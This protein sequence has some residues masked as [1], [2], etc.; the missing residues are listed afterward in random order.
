MSKTLQERL[1]SLKDEVT[2]LLAAVIVDD[3]STA[4]DQANLLVEKALEQVKRIRNVVWGP[5]TSTPSNNTF[6]C[7][8]KEEG[9]HE[10]YKQCIVSSESSE[11]K[12][13]KTER[14]ED[15]S[16]ESLLCNQI[17]TEK[18]EDG[19]DSDKTEDLNYDNA[20]DIDDLDDINF[21]DDNFSNIP[22]TPKI[23]QTKAQIKVDGEPSFDEDD[24]RNLIKNYNNNE[25]D[26]VA[27]DEEEFSDEFDDDFNEDDMQLLEEAERSIIE[28]E[29]IGDKE[30]DDDAANQPEDKKFLDVLKQYFGYS[31][32]RPM[33]WKIINSVV[34]EKKDNCVI[35]A[36][37]HGKSLC[38][39]YPS[40]FTGKTTVVISPL[41][42]LMEDQ[43]LGLKAANIEACLLGS[44]QENS[45]QVMSELMRGQY[46]VLYITP[47]YASTGSNVLTDLNTKIGIDL[48]AIDEAHC[49]SQW[50]HDFRSAYRSLGSLKD[51]FPDVPVM[52]L[53]A[54]ATV[55]VRRDI[56]RSLKLR[57]PVVTCTGFDRPN[58][59]L[60]V[61]AKA[62][63][64][65]DL[66]QHMM[67]KDNKFEFDGPTIIYC[68]T[69][70]STM[71][72]TSVLK[73]QGVL[74]LPY[75]AGLSLKARKDAHHKFVND[76]IQVVVATVAFGMGIDKPDVRKVI[77]YGAPKDIES[78][79]QEVGRAGRDGLPSACHVFYSSADFNVSKHFINEINN[80]KFRQ[81]KLKMLGKMVQYLNTA[82]CRRRVLLAHFE[83]RE[84]QELGGT[85][86]CCD[87]CRKKIEVGKKQGFYSSKNWG[88]DAGSV[89]PDK[90]V[91]YSR[92]AKDLFTA[93]EAMGGRFGITSPIQ[94]LVGSNNQRIQRFT[95]DKVWGSGKYRSL[96]WWKGFGK[97]LLFEGYLTEKAVE[98][99]FGST[100]SVSRQ[101]R[102]WLQ[103]YRASPSN[104]LTIMPLQ[105]MLDEERTKSISIR[106][107]PDVRLPSIPYRPPQ[108]TS[109][110]VRMPEPTPKPAPVC[111]RTARLQSEL[112][113]LLMKRRNDVAQDTGFTPHSIASNKVLIDLAKIRPGSKPSML[114]IE[115]FPEAK[116]QRFGD[117]FIKIITTFCQDN[118]LKLDD[119]PSVTIDKGD[120]DF[121]GELMQLTDTQRTSYIM[122]EKQSKTLEDVA[123]LRGFKTSTI[124]THLCEA[125]K[126]GLSVD[127]KR[128]GL[129]PQ[130][131]SKITDVI[132][133]PP[134][135]SCIGSLT[136]IKDQLPMS[137]EYNH[138]K[139]VIAILVQQCGQEVNA[140]GDLVL[141]AGHSI[142]SPTPSRSSSP[143]NKPKLVKAQSVP[144]PQTQ[145]SSQKNFKRKVPGW[146]SANRPPVISKKVRANSLFR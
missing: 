82:Q 56:C 100:V 127:V 91:D 142:T 37:G 130:L 50:G 22:D 84:M 44:A 92:E 8:Q 35:M 38:Y 138:I 115:D 88:M 9:Y 32:F 105:D 11:C 129:V 111:E 42:S 40:V 124:V 55:D 110:A 78:Y 79:Y 146:M 17:K 122:F 141:L 126:V 3:I 72:V 117:T 128:L 39:Q 136:K 94:L 45:S 103:K 67:K 135:N 81:H 7:V 14:I 64:W 98:H 59:F 101:G 34:N 134:V 13:L 28:E 46:R 27:G 114:K 33:Q 145:G 4:D 76:R 19:F 20:A 144:S 95:K 26:D 25:G 106:V 6:E 75:H 12:Q 10:P 87:N 86:N 131:L 68:P 104:T 66:K 29:Q 60:S 102:E 5:H 1:R 113:I 80:E 140:Q 61:A 90:P 137:V 49:V 77:H 71:E 73:T 108:S 70:K 139:V 51:K 143:G 89:A 109:T 99:G 116:V 54:T 65:Y 74:C 69:K 119:F 41:I 133:R 96:K 120:G 23:N 107:T 15:V 24:M 47:E 31:K 52:A 21:E 118:D 30:E 125:L 62:E 53:T 63:V 93:I 85:E 97:C 123:S 57:N 36:T 16:T 18:V 2:S 121:H 48:I 58:L 43:V 112:Y 132:R 83:G